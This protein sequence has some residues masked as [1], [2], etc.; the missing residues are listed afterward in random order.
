MQ[1]RGDR[2]GLGTAASAL[3]AVAAWRLRSTLAHRTARGLR[4][5]V[6]AER[7]W[8]RAAR[9]ARW[10]WTSRAHGVAKLPGLLRAGELPVAR[11]VL[12]LA[13]STG[14][15]DRHVRRSTLT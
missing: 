12:R 8:T 15:A 1:E 9:A 11:E 13:L 5:A 2:S 10:H 7:G 14:S 4:A 6:L 3:A